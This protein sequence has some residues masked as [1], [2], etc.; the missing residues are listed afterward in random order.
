MTGKRISRWFLAV[1]AVAALL[2]PGTG[3]F[4]QTTGTLEG[5]VVDENS[6]AVPG[7]TIE[8]SSPSLQGTKVVVSDSSGRFR[9]VLLPP[10]SYTLRAALEGYATTEQPG[11]V[12]GLGKVVT[13]HVVMH[14]AFKEEVLVTGEAPLVDVRSNEASMNVTVGAIQSLPTGRNYA[15]VALMMPGAQAQTDTQMPDG[16]SLY[17]S[18]GAENAYYIDGVNTTGVELSVQG[19]QLNF[20]FIQE[21]QV[22]AG[23]YMAEY[24]RS[25]GGMINVITKS[26]GNEFSGDVFGYYDSDSLRSDFSTENLAVSRETRTYIVDAYTKA[27]FGVDLG[28]AIV[29]DKLWFF[30]AYDRVEEDEDRMITKD[31]TVFGGPAQ[32]TVYVQSGSRDLWAGKLTW[33]MGQNHSLIVSAFADPRTTEGPLDAYALAGPE[34]TFVGILDEG[35]TDYTAKYEGVLGQ[36]VVLGAQYAN[37]E[38]MYDPSASPGFTEIWHQDRTY[39]VGGGTFPVSGGFGFAQLQEFGREIWKADMALF[40]NAL[41]DHEIKFGVEWETVDVMSNQYDTGTQRIRTR[42]MSGTQLTDPVTHELIGCAPG[43]TY[44]EHEFYM[45]SRPGSVTDPNMASYVANGFPVTSGADNYTAFLQDSWRVSPSFTLNLGVRADQQKLYNSA[46]ATNADI[47]D[48]APR[49]GFVW[50][51]SGTG[52]SKLYGSWGYFYETIPMD[53]VIRSFGGEITALTYNRTGDGSDVVCRPETGFRSCR[54]VGKENTPVDPDIAG[55]YIEEV[56]VGADFEVVK[57]LVLGA[58]YI[59]RDL[60]RV[61]EDS[62]ASD[63][64]YY[65]GNPGEGL[66]SEMYD[67]TYTYLY[68]APKPKRTFTGVELTARKRLSDNWQFLASYLWSELEGNYDGTFQASTGQLDPNLNSAFDY[69]EFSVQNYGY[70]SVDRTHQ[71]KIDGYYTFDFGLDIGLSA[72]YITGKPVTAYGFDVSYRN[73]EYYLSERGAY[74][75]TDDEYEMDLHL[76][77]PIKLGG[78]QVNL[79]FDVFNLLDRQGETDRDMRF[80]LD[81][82]IDVI[83]YDTGEINPLLPGGTTCESL[84]VGSCNPNFNKSNTFQDPRSIRIGVRLSF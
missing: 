36:N 31:W 76:G 8:L 25:T 58:K 17:G 45:T 44:Y 80:N 63:G 66:L 29:K 41:G 9:Q 51:W 73:Y 77:Y 50:D 23:G 20:E 47:K 39:T 59:W 75:R 83:N 2:V 46:G 82:T 79:L 74:G 11:I 71:F 6:Q 61:I 16:I 21:L 70:L 7:V 10:G 38:E 15:S 48:Y 54:I 4:A 14:S 42:C 72:Y 43:G 78:V 35:G 22:K 69:A 56:I 68:P 3:A 40:V 62:L 81:Q 55:Q 67:E 27:D 65:L 37:H 26:G 34:S 28:G 24:G 53:M 13:V 30:A 60:P 84:G 12:V 19:K 52:A 33:R 18:S 1:V 32:D 57:D 5:T 49:L 64:S